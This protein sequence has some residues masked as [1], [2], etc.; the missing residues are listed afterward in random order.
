[1]RFQIIFNWFVSRSPRMMS[2]SR[3]AT[4]SPASLTLIRHIAPFRASKP[5]VPISNNP[6]FQPKNHQYSQVATFK[7][8][9][10]RRNITLSYIKHQSGLALVFFTSTLPGVFNRIY[11]HFAIKTRR[12]SMKKCNPLH[13]KLGWFVSYTHA[14]A[15]AYSC[16]RRTL[17]KWPAV[18][19]V[20]VSLSPRCTHLH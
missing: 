2:L 8:D 17:P 7:L 20:I 16:Y 15:R 18:P 1:M 14:S 4:N 11:I 6:L 5:G 13:G 9:I 12:P 3:S 19:M 10:P